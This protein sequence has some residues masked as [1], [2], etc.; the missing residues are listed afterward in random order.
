MG[1]SIRLYCF[2]SSDS[3]PLAF[4]YGNRSISHIA[5]ACGIMILSSCLEQRLES[6]RGHYHRR[7]HCSHSHSFRFR[8]QKDGPFIQHRPPFSPQMQ[9]MRDGVRLRVDSP[10]ITHF[11]PPPQ[12]SV[13]H[14]SCL[15]KMVSV[16]YLEYQG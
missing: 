15:Q 6:N 8:A 11:P 16:R 9:Q 7:H 14:V 5:N 13:S 10:G 2:T 12:L 4:N 3:K 1:V